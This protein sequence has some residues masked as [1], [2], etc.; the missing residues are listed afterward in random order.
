MGFVTFGLVFA[1]VGTAKR[2]RRSAYVGRAV[3]APSVHTLV[4]G[5]VARIANERSE[6]FFRAAS[7]REVAIKHWLGK[8]PHAEPLAV[9]FGLVP[10]P[11]TFIDAP[12]WRPCEC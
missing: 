8:L 12:S 10:C 5:A 9:D 2:G 3:W 11:V 4:L 7:T 6:I 1:Y